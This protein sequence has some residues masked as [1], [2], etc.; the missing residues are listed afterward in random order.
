MPKPTGC[1][2]KGQLTYW[3]KHH[4][5]MYWARD[6]ARQHKVSRSVVSSTLAELEMNGWATRQ[7][8][9]RNTR[10]VVRWRG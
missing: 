3:L 1:T 6:L 7:M 8:G 5:G 9:G 10:W 2:A 4:P